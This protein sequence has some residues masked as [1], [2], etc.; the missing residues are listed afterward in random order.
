MKT[1]TKVRLTLVIMVLLGIIG[2]QTHL[3][4]LAS[5][6]EVEQVEAV[7][8]S[9]ECEVVRRTTVKYEDNYKDNMEQ[10]RLQVLLDMNNE[11]QGM[12]TDQSKRLNN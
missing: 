4:V 8:T 11:M 6:F 3:L 2:F 12:V 7:C 1:K 5:T 9:I 10:A